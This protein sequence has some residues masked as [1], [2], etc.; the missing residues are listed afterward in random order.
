MDDNLPAFNGL[1]Y[2][3]W[4]CLFTNRMCESRPLMNDYLTDD[5]GI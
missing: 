2:V 3:E 5:T 4:E 1:K